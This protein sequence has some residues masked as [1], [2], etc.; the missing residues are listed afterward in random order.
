MGTQ[1]SLL[2]F[3][4]TIILHTYIISDLASNLDRPA[5]DP[6]R[7]DYSPVDSKIS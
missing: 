5:L 6:V 3:S 2:R 1:L 4:K 7:H